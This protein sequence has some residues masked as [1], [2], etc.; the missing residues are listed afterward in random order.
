MLFLLFVLVTSICTAL[1]LKLYISAPRL[2]RMVRLWGVIALVT[3]ASQDQSC[4]R[5]LQRWSERA[6]SCRS[7]RAAFAQWVCDCLQSRNGWTPEDLD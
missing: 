3:A 4:R 2:N 7:E 5:A 6:A 1:L